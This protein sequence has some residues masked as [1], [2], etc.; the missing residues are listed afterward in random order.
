MASRRCFSLIGEGTLPLSPAGNVGS[1]I[2]VLTVMCRFRFTGIRGF[3]VI[4]ADTLL[5]C[6]KPA[7]NAVL[8]T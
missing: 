3:I 6:L 5:P 1:Y 4:I 8:N 7:L 2:N